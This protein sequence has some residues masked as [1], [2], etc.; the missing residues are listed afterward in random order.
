MF[1]FFGISPKT[2]HHGFVRQQCQV[3][4]GESWME[5]VSQ[6]SWFNLFFFLKLFPIG[7]GHH[8]L[9]CSECGATFELEEHE[10]VEMARTA[11]TDV[12]VPQRGGLFGGFP[13]GGFFGGGD[14][15]A[16]QQQRG[17]HRQDQ[18]A[19]DQYT[20]DPY[21]Q[22]QYRTEPY[23]SDRPAGQFA[24]APYADAPYAEPAQSDEPPVRVQSRR[25]DRGA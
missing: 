14:P 3:H 24:D 1:L 13:F 11:R 19:P 5:L 9:T 4:R 23:P 21:P 22:D 17:G 15:Y 16:G 2:K 7:R 20:A 25:L 18:Y 12:D 8:L 10:A 6:R